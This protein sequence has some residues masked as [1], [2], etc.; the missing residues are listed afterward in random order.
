ME[1]LKVQPLSPKKSPTKSPKRPP[2]PPLAARVKVAVRVRPPVV[3]DGDE[4]PP[5]CITNEGPEN[6]TNASENLIHFQVE[7]MQ[8]SFRFDHVFS[9][10]AAQ[11]DVH[12]TALQPLL[13]SLMHGFNVTV[14]AYGQ[15]GSGKTHTMGGAETSELQSGNDDGLILRFVRDLFNALGTEAS[16]KT[17]IKVSF[18]EIYCDEIRDLLVDGGERARSFSQNGSRVSRLTIHEDDYDVRVEGLQQVKVKSVAEALAL[19]RTG[20]QRQTIGAHALNDQSSR[21]H[22][23]YTLEISRTFANEIKRAKLTFVDLAGSERVKKTLMEGQ[24]MREGSHINIGLLALGN[25]INALGSRH[26][27]LQR[28]NSTGI[29][30]RKSNITGSDEMAS[31][32]PAHVPYRSSKLTRLLRDALGGNSVTLFIACISPEITNCNETLC[33]LQY[34]NRARSIQNKAQKNVEEAVTEDVMVEDP[35][36][37]QAA[38][39]QREIYALREQVAALKMQLDQAVAAVKA[40]E[41][42]DSTFAGKPQEPNSSG[43]VASLKYPKGKRRLRIAALELDIPELLSP[44]D[45]SFSLESEQRE[46][47]LKKSTGNFKGHDFSVC[48][49]TATSMNQSTPEVRAP[50]GPELPTEES[51]LTERVTNEVVPRKQFS[52]SVSVREMI[53]QST[54]YE[55]PCPQQQR[56]IPVDYVLLSPSQ[57]FREVHSQ[58][59]GAHS[60]WPHRRRLDIQLHESR[61]SNSPNPNS[62]SCSKTQD[63]LR[64]LLQ[65][66]QLLIDNSLHLELEDTKR[67]EEQQAPLSFETF[68]DQMTALFDQRRRQLQFV[69]RLTQRF[70]HLATVLSVAD[71][72]SQ[73]IELNKYTLEHQQDALQERLEAF[74]RLAADR[75]WIRL[76]HREVATETYAGIWNDK[77][78]EVFLFEDQYEAC[79]TWHTRR[80]DH[81]F[82]QHHI[83]PFILNGWIS[84]APTDLETEQ[85]WF[86]L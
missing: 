80:E 19:L 84:V 64:G 52:P 63:V 15:T 51:L 28:R 23:V 59:L 66:T 4:P 79:T 65:R 50:F 54:Q 2:P 13:A 21:S 40:V 77:L 5:L 7:A 53:D 62:S 75:L 55:P 45:S 24:G 71:V 76:Q 34:A 78:T 82:F 30:G 25:V 47:V 29:S 17:T 83:L 68:V 31:L 60:P 20:R 26:R 33:T 41:V 48:S 18:L 57:V 70:R 9:S 74:E 86:T 69:H 36:V 37:V 81:E 58:K 22:A 44:K 11:A 35:S 85:L 72:D 16:L 73:L 3:C 67:K 39:S 27:R 43:N 14:L 8:K 49:S 46:G 6:E 42:R 56:K 32:G 61:C 38:E 12:N 1:E 10:E